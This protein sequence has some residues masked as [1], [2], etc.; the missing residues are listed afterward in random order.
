MENE[1]GGRISGVVLRDLPFAVAFVFIILFVFLVPFINPSQEEDVMIKM[2]GN[3]MIQIVWQ[4]NVDVDVDLWARA[5][6]DEVIGYSNRAG[7][8]FNLLRDD[9]GT[10]RDTTPYNYEVMFGRDMP[11]GTYT[12]NVHLYRNGSESLEVPVY[13]DVYISRGSKTVSIA[14]KSV[15]LSY[16]GDEITVVNFTIENEILIGQPNNEFTPLRSQALF[17]GAP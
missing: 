6:G 1:S 2:P 12:V 14:K 9:L 5:P 17:G 11:N 16:L 15:V 10:L 3:I 8:T 13:V 4:D 7:Q